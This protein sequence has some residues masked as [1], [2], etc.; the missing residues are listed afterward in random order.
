MTINTDQPTAAVAITAEIVMTFISRNALPASELPGLI[1][2]THAA[3][4]AL[5]APAAEPAPL[6]PPVPI[7]KTIAPIHIISL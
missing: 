6:D 1:A 4:V 5:S 2:S 3:I 7:R